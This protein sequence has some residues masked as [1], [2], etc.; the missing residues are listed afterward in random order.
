[1][2]LAGYDPYGAAGALAKLNMVSGPA[3]ILAANFDD[4]P[5]P[6]VSFAS[7]LDSMFSTLSMACGQPALS[8]YC[9][10]YKSVIHPNFPPGA[11]F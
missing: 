4:L 11:P 1:M 9:S 7:R 8:L 5:D 2:L 3:G 10:A 6:H